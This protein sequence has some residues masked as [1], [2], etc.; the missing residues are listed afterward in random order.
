MPRRGAEERKGRILA[1]IGCHSTLRQA[2]HLFQS[3]L[4]RYFGDAC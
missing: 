1:D 3:L 2:E 4:N